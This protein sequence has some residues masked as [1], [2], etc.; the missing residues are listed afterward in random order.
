MSICVLHIWFLLNNLFPLK[1]NHMKF[2][3]KV[4]KLKRKTQVLFQTLPTFPL[5]SYTPAF[6]SLKHRHLCAMDTFFLFWGRG[7][8]GSYA[9]YLSKEILPKW[10]NWRQLLTRWG[11]TGSIEPL[12]WHKIT[13][14]INVRFWFKSHFPKNIK[15]AIIINKEWL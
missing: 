12:V 6:F 5:W 10:V 7:R 13:S 1:K 8:V 9:E 3:Y 2:M 15:L 11:I 4:R 14:H